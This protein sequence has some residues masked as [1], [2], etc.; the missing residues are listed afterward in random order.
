MIAILRVDKSTVF[1]NHADLRLQH[2]QVKESGDTGLGRECFVAKMSLCHLWDD[3]AL[4][5]TRLQDFFGFLWSDVSVTDSRAIWHRNI[6]DRFEVTGTDTSD[7]NDS[8]R[9]TKF[10]HGF[11]DGLQNIKRTSRNPAGGST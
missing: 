2:G 5:Q 3:I 9:L 8:D 1:Q 6:H 4:G 10:S 11:V 7:L